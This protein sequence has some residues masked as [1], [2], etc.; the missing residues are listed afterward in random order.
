MLD[1]SFEEKRELLNNF[2]KSH[3]IDLD[4]PMTCS[5]SAS[6]ESK[7]SEAMDVTPDVSLLVI[8]SFE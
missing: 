2:V 3:G 8:Y 6:R 4:T 7:Q 1:Y 5:S